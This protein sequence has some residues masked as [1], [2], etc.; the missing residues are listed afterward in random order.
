MA[1]AKG[2]SGNPNGRPAGAKSK[3]SIAAIREQFAAGQVLLLDAV[4]KKYCEII[5]AG[6]HEALERIGVYDAPAWH[7]DVRASDRISAAKLFL[8]YSIGRPVDTVA[9][10]DASADAYASQPTA[11]TLLGIFDDAQPEPPILVA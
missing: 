7:A 9:L 1:W 8:E 5:F 3:N 6:D 4:A 10:I 11:S 2:T